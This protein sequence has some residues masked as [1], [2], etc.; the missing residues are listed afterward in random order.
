MSN[1][2][3]DLERQ[4]QADL[5]KAIALSLEAS[6]FERIQSEQ[7]RKSLNDGI[8]WRVDG[9]SGRPRPGPA[10]PTASIPPLS[11]PPKTPPIYSQVNKPNKTSPSLP[12]PPSTRKQSTPN[13]STEV[14]DLI[15]FHS[16]TKPDDPG[17]NNAKNR[18]ALYPDLD[19]FLNDVQPSASTSLPSTSTPF[20]SPLAI[21]C[22]KTEPKKPMSLY[23]M[24]PN[25]HPAISL[26]IGFRREVLP[27]H[28]PFPRPALAL[29]DRPQWGTEDVLRTLGKRE[30]NNLIDLSPNRPS[31]DGG[32]VLDAFDP[33]APARAPPPDPVPEEEPES[34]YAESTAD[35]SIYDT[36]DPFDYMYSPTSL[37][38]SQ[39][40][41]VYAAVQDQ[42]PEPVSRLLLLY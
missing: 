23:N 5:E 15:S 42:L 22:V 1:Q 25:P 4:F 21:D 30:N 8:G 36:F 19:I 34:A 7:R 3:D 14:N 16:P 41:P 35:E 27:R 17:L 9:T 31:V 20:S 11:A 2:E 37:D 32:S 40:E 26:D 38:G 24:F 6:E 29:S 13:T 39:G 10:R 33:L 18:F 12:P 28:A